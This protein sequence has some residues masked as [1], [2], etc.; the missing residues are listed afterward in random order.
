MAS[1]HGNWDVAMSTDYLDFSSRSGALLDWLKD[2]GK[3][4]PE[5]EGD[6]NKLWV[7]LAALKKR[8]DEW[9]HSAAIVDLFLVMKEQRRSSMT[10]RHV[11]HGRLLNGKRPGHIDAPA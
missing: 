7:E 10:D 6:A 1:A 8:R 2:V 3:A 9:A 4:H 11:E 5:V